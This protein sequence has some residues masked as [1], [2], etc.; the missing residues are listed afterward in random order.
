[1]FFFA[2]NPA[3]LP[4]KRVLQIMLGTPATL[5]VYVSGYPLVASSQIHW[6][7]PN[8]TEILEGQARFGNGRRTMFLSEVQSTDGGLYRCEVNTSYGDRSTMIQLD[9]YGMKTILQDLNNWGEFPF[10]IC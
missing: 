3:I 6:Y 1:M 4:V 9:V 8:G 2:D 5:Q 7:R 10:Q